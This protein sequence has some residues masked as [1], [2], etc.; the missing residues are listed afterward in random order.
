MAG[1]TGKTNKN[2]NITVTGYNPEAKCG[3]VVI[4]DR[5]EHQEKEAYQNLGS[6]VSQLDRYA[7]LVNAGSW[8]VPGLG[9]KGYV[10][11]RCQGQ[12]ENDG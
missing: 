6:W 1:E 7:R 9:R 5:E 2:R 10:Y 11:G 4:Y 8:R 3:V 12:P